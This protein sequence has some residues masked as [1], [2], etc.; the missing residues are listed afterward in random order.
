MEG[1]TLRQL[2]WAWAFTATVNKEKAL[3]VA[4]SAR[5]ALADPKDYE[6]WINSLID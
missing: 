6:K 2:I 5:Y 4:Q 3:L 1:M